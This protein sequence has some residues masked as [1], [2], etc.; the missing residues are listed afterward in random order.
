LANHKSAAKRARQSIKRQ[1]R[2]SHTQ[3]TVRSSEK[4]LRTAISENNKEQSETLLKDYISKIAKAAQKG[5]YHANTASRKI[6]R[7]SKLVSSSAN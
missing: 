1:Q 2:S 6:G 5:Y 7:L 3:K 4:K